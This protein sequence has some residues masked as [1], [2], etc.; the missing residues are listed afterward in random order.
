MS[1]SVAEAG[2]YKE[3]VLEIKGDRCARERGVGRER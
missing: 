2:G 3:C 1:E